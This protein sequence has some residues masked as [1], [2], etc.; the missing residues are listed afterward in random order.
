VSKGKRRNE[1]AKLMSEQ[2]IKEKSERRKER[3]KMREV[4]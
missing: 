3:G 1:T 4:K 2:R